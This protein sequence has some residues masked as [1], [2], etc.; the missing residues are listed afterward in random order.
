MKF[1]YFPFHRVQHVIQL[2]GSDVPRHLVF[3]TSHFCSVYLVL[4]FIDERKIN[5]PIR[6]QS[7]KQFFILIIRPYQRGDQYNPEFETQKFQQMTDR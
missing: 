7:K 1:P 3:N 6:C 5:F 2:P 4:L